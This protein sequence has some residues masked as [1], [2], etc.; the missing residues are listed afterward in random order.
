MTIPGDP[1]LRKHA[2]RPKLDP[3][4]QEDLKRPALV[5]AGPPRLLVDGHVAAGEPFLEL[6]VRHALT[7]VLAGEVA[8][9]GWLGGKSLP[10]GAPVYGLAMGGPD[11][12]G[13]VWCAPTQ[14]PKDGAWS[15][16][17]LPFGDKH[18]VW[19]R[20]KPALLPLALSWDDRA[21]QRTSV[22]QV[23][24][25]PVTLPPLKLR[26]VFDGLDD[27]GWVKIE[28]QVDWGEG[29]QMLRRITLAPGPDGAAV[30]KLLDGR[31]ALKATAPATPDGAAQAVVEVRT[32]LQPDAA[33]TY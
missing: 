33:I 29:P 31:V 2:Q 23:T 21:V 7:G 14:A 3:A 6:P 26:Y 8:M 9:K 18:H 1:P 11:G 4:I 5:A 28:T 16:V 27:K 19:T 17:C 30:V 20:A 13:L 32:P 10:A 22:P 15:A 12:P 24:R 25:Q